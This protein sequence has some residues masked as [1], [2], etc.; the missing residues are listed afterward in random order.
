MGG[1]GEFGF[2]KLFLKDVLFYFVEMVYPFERHEFV[3][4][5]LLNPS[6]ERRASGRLP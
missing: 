6:R 1:G 5:I 3:S 2:N 4:V